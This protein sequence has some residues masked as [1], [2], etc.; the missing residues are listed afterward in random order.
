MIFW[1]REGNAS[2][3]ASILRYYI[4][5][6]WRNKYIKGSSGPGPEDILEAFNN[7]VLP[8]GWTK[9]IG[10]LDET[11]SLLPAYGPGDQAH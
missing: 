7:S 2:E 4:T 3:G 9:Q 10:Y 8:E 5:D 1:A 6:S 11:I